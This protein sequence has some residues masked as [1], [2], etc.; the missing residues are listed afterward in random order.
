MPVVETSSF[1]PVWWLRNPHAQTIWPAVFRRIPKPAWKRERIELSDGDFID[2]DWSTVGAKRLVVVTHGLEGNSR[3]TYVTG[4][5]R[6]FNRRGWD[7]LAWSFRGCSGTPNRLPKAYHSGA[8]ED[9]QAVID[10][11]LA[12]KKYD[13]VAVVGFS[14]G[15]N[16]TLKY[17]GELGTN[18]GIVCGGIGVSVPCDL[19]ASA[20]H[21]ARPECA[22]YM[23]RFLKEMGKR[24]EAKRRQFGDR[25]TSADFQAMRTF[26]E[27][28]DAY[29]APLHG[30]LDAHDY[31]AKCS[32]SRFLPS[33]RI[34]TLIINAQDDPFLAPAC[35][36][37]EAAR[38]SD[39]V[40]LDA[41]AHGGHVGF[42]GRGQAT[43]E[44]WSE[45]RAAEF[46]E[47]T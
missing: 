45:S 19:R 38:N 34:P 4:M 43:G 7:A 41:P 37:W 20:E 27:F 47:E 32:A 30:F 46:L 8:C 26:K 2:A 40:H 23:R 3:Q 1:K 22:F 13:R 31:W 42:V 36:P 9:L 16:L 10:I 11:A 24:I 33:I 35:H 44:Y 21:M 15:G 25:I 17:L 5:V 14:L 28:D 12:Q 18:P 39:C 29:T 6:A